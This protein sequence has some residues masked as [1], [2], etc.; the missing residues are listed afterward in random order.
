[1]TLQSS[2]YVLITGATSG[3][4]HELAKIFAAH[5]YNLVIVARSAS[6]LAVVARELSQQYGIEAIAIEKDLFNVQSPF[7]L[8]KEI[9]SRGIKIDVLVNN[10]G[11]GVYGKFVDTDLRAELDIIQL[12]INAY[13]VLT[14]LFLRDMIN[15]QGGKIL[16]VA[17]IAG[18]VP[19]P[20]QSVYHGTKA[21]VHSFTEAIR[22]EL[23]DTNITITSLLPGPTNTDFFNKAK[24]QD[25]KI[26][27][28]HLADAATVAADGFNALMKGDDMMISGLKNKAQV[29]MSNITP[30]RKV[31]RQM[32]DQ[33]EPKEAD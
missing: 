33:Q 27:E 3:I 5:N 11:Q 10:A 19:G 8:H 28:H 24:M 30:D 31:A 32:L 2:Q 23:A 6:D 29:A 26:L 13:V 4:G 14:K 16:N 12:N 21:F 22:A 20:F 9:H 1:M 7:E 17:S 18:K 15:N 25:S